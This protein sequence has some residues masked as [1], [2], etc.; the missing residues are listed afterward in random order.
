MICISLGALIF[1]SAMCW[2]NDLRKAVLLCWG[3]WLLGFFVIP[4][5]LGEGPYFLVL[6][7]LLGLTLLLRWKIDAALP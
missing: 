5:I 2:I 4:W 3:I 6:Q 1:G 7:T